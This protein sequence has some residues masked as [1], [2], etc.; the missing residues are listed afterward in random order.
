[1]SSL[2]RKRIEMLAAVTCGWLAVSCP[3]P[4]LVNLALG[5]TVFLVFCR[6]LDFWDGFG[7]SH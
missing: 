1:M 7:G 5:F 6:L 4:L 2:Q 3:G